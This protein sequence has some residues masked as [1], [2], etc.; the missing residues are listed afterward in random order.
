[1]P[2]LPSVVSPDGWLRSTHKGVQMSNGNWAREA[3]I[4]TPEES[5]LQTVYQLQNDIEDRK[6]DVLFQLGALRDEI[7]MGLETAIS[8]EPI[9]LARFDSA[10]LHYGTLL[11]DMVRFLDAIITYNKAV[12][13]IE[14]VL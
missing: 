6:E 13:E 3:R 4:F 9:D 7:E 5:A 14:E 2:W 11:E 8:G 1:M 10:R 12:D